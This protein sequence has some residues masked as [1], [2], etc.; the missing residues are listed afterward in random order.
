MDSCLIP[1]HTGHGASYTHSM[2]STV[3]Q[4]DATTGLLTVHSIFVFATLLR[5]FVNQVNMEKIGIQNQF[6]GHFK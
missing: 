3:V 4:S 6:S 5:Y 1:G 2:C